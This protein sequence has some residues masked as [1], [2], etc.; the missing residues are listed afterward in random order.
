MKDFYTETF[1]KAVNETANKDGLI[2]AAVIV[3]CRVDKM[4]ISECC[5]VIGLGAKRVKAVLSKFDVYLA[6]MLPIADT[7]KLSA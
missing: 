2:D 6:S 7:D 3:S 1:W 4:P 5:A